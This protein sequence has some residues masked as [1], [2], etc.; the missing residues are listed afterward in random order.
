MN[1]RGARGQASCHCACNATTSSR[2]RPP[3]PKTRQRLGHKPQHQRKGEAE[4]RNATTEGLNYTL[5]RRNPDG[6]VQ[7]AWRHVPPLAISVAAP[8]L[9]HL[10]TSPPGLS[11]TTRPL[12][13]AEMS[14]ERTIWVDLAPAES[15]MWEAIHR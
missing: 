9:S 2:W 12:T 11:V 7:L 5:V 14:G 10:T 6:T 13:L 15:K 3:N 4:R 1:P 8:G